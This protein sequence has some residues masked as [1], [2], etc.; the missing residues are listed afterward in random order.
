M[1]QPLFDKNQIYK[2]MAENIPSEHLDLFLIAKVLGVDLKKLEKEFQEY[3]NNKKT[4][5]R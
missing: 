1:I 4:L 5:D 3:K 2:N